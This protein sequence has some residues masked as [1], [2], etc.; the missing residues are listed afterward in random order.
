MRE[1]DSFDTMSK[2]S[3]FL[4]VATRFT[5]ILFSHG[6]HCFPLTIEFRLE[7]R[8]KLNFRLRLV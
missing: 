5:Q 7:H 8:E 2:V 6:G 3:T 4:V 1:S